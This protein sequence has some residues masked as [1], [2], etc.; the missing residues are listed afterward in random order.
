MLRLLMVRFTHQGHAIGRSEL[1]PCIGI[2]PGRGS[3]IWR[4]WYT[5]N[6]V[7]ATRGAPTTLAAPL[8][9]INVHIRDG[10]AILLHS[11][12]AYTIE[13]TRQGP[14]SLLV[15][16]SS[17]GRAFGTAYIDDGVSSPP[18]P[19]KTLT[20]SATKQQ[21]TISARGSFTVKQQLKVVTVLGLK[22]KPS[23]LFLNGKR[24]N[25]WSFSAPQGKLV[26]ELSVNLNSPATLE[27]S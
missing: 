2:F 23:R 15:S 24:I 8:G 5:H 16:Q 21:L 20:F 18:G 1:I 17:N 26:V 6:V 22:S 25:T 9:H 12:P 19:S 7:N 10:A 14:F 11:T 27:W 3:V 13:E 4:D